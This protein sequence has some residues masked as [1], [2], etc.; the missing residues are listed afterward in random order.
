MFCFD[1][2][3]DKFLPLDIRQLKFSILIGSYHKGILPL[4]VCAVVGAPLSTKS[5]TTFRWPAW[6][7]QWRGVQPLWKKKL[8]RFNRWRK[9]RHSRTNI[10]KSLGQIKGNWGS[11]K[12]H[13]LTRCFP[14]RIEPKPRWIQ[15]PNL[16]CQI[17]KKLQRRIVTMRFK[18]TLNWVNLICWIAWGRPYLHVAFNIL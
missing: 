13:S 1:I 16:E 3:K 9:K 11:K 4:V 14:R 5:L 15:A 8:K 17:V 18:G 2:T 10:W 7:A 6:A 12:L